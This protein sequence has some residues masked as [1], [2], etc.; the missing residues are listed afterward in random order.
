M[1]ALVEK[2]SQDTH[3]VEI[4]L[5]PERSAK[6]LEQSI[7]R[8]LVHVKFTDT[9]GGTELGVRLDRDASALAADYD[10]GTGHITLVGHLTLDYQKVRC[11]AEIDVA[12]LTGSGRL[13][14]L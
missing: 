3:P 9:R 11:V 1:S 7:E 8:G 12:T 2:L 4:S 5:R 13:I 10:S 6:A 14:K